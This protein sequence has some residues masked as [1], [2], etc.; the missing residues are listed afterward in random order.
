MLGPIFVQFYY[1]LCDFAIEPRKFLGSKP[2]AKRIGVQAYCV[3]FEQLIAVTARVARRHLHDYAPDVLTP[4][5]GV[6]SS[7]I[8]L[9]CDQIAR[10]YHIHT[11]ENSRDWMSN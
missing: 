4:I 1:T 8:T 11:T 10:H 5:T 2:V 6:Y 3:T 7:G 9:K